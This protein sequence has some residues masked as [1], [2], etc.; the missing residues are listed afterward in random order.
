[1]RSDLN[2]N[3]HNGFALRFKH[4]FKTPSPKVNMFKNNFTYSRA[5]IWNTIPVEI[6]NTNIIDSFVN[7]EIKQSIPC[8][9]IRWVPRE[10]LKTEG[11]T[12]TH[13]FLLQF[14]D[15]AWFSMH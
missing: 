2:M 15:Q 9:N 3:L 7:I 11:A 14:R 10:V 4:E 6:S 13:L 8:I 1:M 5:L 12:P